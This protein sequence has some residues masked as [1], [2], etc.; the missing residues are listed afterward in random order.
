MRLF[1]YWREFHPADRG[2]QVRVIEK[3][4]KKRV[5]LTDL[6]VSKTEKK[7]KKEGGKKIKI[8]FSERFIEVKRGMRA[9]DCSA[10][11]PFL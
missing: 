7:K 8:R 4:K 3:K 2:V 11:N 6:S 10:R 5:T 9:R 1:Y